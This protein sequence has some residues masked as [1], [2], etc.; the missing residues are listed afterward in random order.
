M[1]RLKLNSTYQSE[2]HVRETCNVQCTIF[3]TNIRQRS[4]RIK[5]CLHRIRIAV[6]RQ[7]AY[8]PEEAHDGCYA[9]ILQKKIDQI[10]PKRLSK[11]IQL[12]AMGNSGLLLY[13]SSRY[14]YTTMMKSAYKKARLATIT[15]I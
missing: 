6:E 10:T 1:L 7:C 5:N 11:L 13:T 2:I 8:D 12:T 3:P 4:F 15:N 9:E 14:M